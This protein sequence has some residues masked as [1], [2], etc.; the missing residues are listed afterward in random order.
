M[1]KFLALAALIS[2]GSVHAEELKFGDLNYFLKAGQFNLGADVI[3]NNE[4]ARLNET[5]KTEVNAFFVNTHYAYALS[6]VFNVT[7]GVN[8]LHDGETKFGTLTSTDTAGLQNPTL[9]LNYRVL[10][11][12]NS[13]VNFDLG[14][15]ASVKLMD[16]EAD[17]NGN[18]IDP[19]LS[20]Y[21]EPRNSLDLTARVGKKWNEANEFYLLGGANYHAE[22]EYDDVNGS[23]TELDS[24]IDFKLGGFY[25]YRPVNEFMMTLGLT[26][27]RYSEYD[28]EVGPATIESEDHIDYQFSFNAKYLI[29]DKVIAKFIFT[30]DRRED[31][32]LGATKIDRRNGA[33]YG[34][35]FD[36]LF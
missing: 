21:F 7:L 11:Q 26:G 20:N 5:T 25:Q 33:Q 2:V 10:Q 6:D 18:M 36:I 4:A 29:T 28:R 3:V 30:Q 16:R 22:G 34:L 13:G 35:G 14:A 17:D 19:V 12:N 24:S 31:Y 9:G 8:Y 32:D 23:E 27:V 15:V 1:K